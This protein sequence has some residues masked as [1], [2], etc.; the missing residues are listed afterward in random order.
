MRSS[1]ADMRFEMPAVADRPPHHNFIHDL[2]TMADHSIRP[3]SDGCQDESSEENLP[4][5]RTTDELPLVAQPS[6]SR[7]RPEMLAEVAEERRSNIGHFQ[8]I[9]V[10]EN[11][12]A[13]RSMLVQMLREWGFE[14]V[15]ATNGAEVLRIVAEKRPPELVILG[16]MLPGVDAFELCGRMSTHEGEYSPYI[17][18]LAMQNDRH[19]V[20]HALE[21]GAAEYLTTP[22]EAQELRARLIVATRI[23]RRQQ[24]LVS[25]R[26]QFRL[27][28]TKDALTGVWNRRS[29]FQILKEELNC[30]A[31]SKRS[32]G[33]LLVDLDYFKQV[34]DT[35]GHLV[36]DLVLRQ[37]SRLLRNAL[38]AYD[39]IGRYGG[40]EFL[41]IT[42]GSNEKELYELGERLRTIIEENPVRVRKN[43]IQIT[44]SIGAAIASP[45]DGCLASVLAAADAALYDAK[46]F[47]RNRIMFGAKRFW[48]SF[49]WT[50]LHG[51]D[52]FPDGAIGSSSY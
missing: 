11:H 40:E 35:H 47:G 23:L 49:N 18:I 34:N 46:R 5:V 32:T 4:G 16:R 51:P 31:R 3:A 25:S 41:I 38:R 52:R 24:N 45:R 48:R 2:V 28:A 21:S 12:G 15:T 19:E 14:V 9:L 13:T 6:N 43:R 39:S 27:Q 42:P 36:G 26:D 29:I 10:A 22:F 30:A 33:V 44:L 50:N 17:L 7:W 20:V 37:T 8:R 1:P